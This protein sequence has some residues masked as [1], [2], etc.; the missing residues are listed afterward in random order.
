MMHYTGG[1]VSD[2]VGSDRVLEQSVSKSCFVGEVEEQPTK[3]SQKCRGVNMEKGARRSVEKLSGVAM[4]KSVRGGVEN[5]ISSTGEIRKEVKREIKMDAL[6]EA[7]DSGKVKVTVADMERDERTWR[8]D[9]FEENST[10][11]GQ[12]EH[13]DVVT[14][15]HQPLLLHRPPRLF[16]LSECS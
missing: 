9:S 12:P 3:K 8:H 11:S 14:K 6:V 5:G 15:C 4:K 16:V 1:E 7:E 13:T 2:R 10:L